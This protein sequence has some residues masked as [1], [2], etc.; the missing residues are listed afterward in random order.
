[1][2]SP[3]RPEKLAE[4]RSAYA[5]FCGSLRE[6]MVQK[7]IS[8]RQL[9]EM[10]NY[11]RSSLADAA[12]GD[13][14]P[15]LELTL[16]FVS[17]CGGSTQEW[18][19]RWTELR[20]QAIHAD[21]SRLSPG[22]I[23]S[24]LRPEQV[25]TPTEF[26]VALRALWR[27]SGLSYGRVERASGGQLRRSTLSDMLTG[28][29]MPTWDTLRIFITTC[30]AH[31]SDKPDLV[32]WRFAAER[33]RAAAEQPAH[34][35]RRTPVS[36]CDPYQLGVHRGYLTGDD[37]ALPTYVHRGAVEE[38]LRQALGE[39]QNR[40]GFVLLIGQSGAG[41]TRLAFEAARTTLRDFGLLHPIS[42]DELGSVPPPRTIVWLDD[43][44]QYLRSGLSRATLQALLRGPRPVIVLGTIWP[45]QY[46]S[47]MTLPRPGTQ[48]A[49]QREREAL[50]LATVIDVDA[51]LSQTELAHARAAARHDPVLAAALNSTDHGIFQT[52]TAGPHLVR[53]WNHAADAYAK[54]LITA[55]VD[56]RRA[57]A[58]EPLT[59]GSLRDAAAAYL[60]ASQ[61]AQAPHDWF[62]KALAYATAPVQGGIAALTP[63]SSTAQTGQ[64][65]GYHVADFLAW[66][67]DRP[68]S[69]PSPAAGRFNQPTVHDARSS[70]KPLPR[71]ALAGL[72]NSNALAWRLNALQAGNR[73]QFTAPAAHAALF[74]SATMVILL[75]AVQGSD[76][77]NQVSAL[78]TR[79]LAAYAGHF[80]S[81]TVRILR[82]AVRGSDAW[83]QVSAAAHTSL[84]N[85]DAIAH[86]LN[87]LREAGASELAT[88]LA[89]RAV[90]HTSLD[91]Q[92]YVALLPET[93]TRGWALFANIT[94]AIRLVI[95]VWIDHT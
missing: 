43:I 83:N 47:Y 37:P 68:D 1:M 74:E 9:A 90:A 7:G 2:D 33:A 31:L 54:A 11:S 24:S 76:A 80:E 29:T 51:G 70:P 75:H 13:R 41:K 84:D 30:A 36:D 52:L 93:D 49:H 92:D 10:T 18:R 82:H 19:R 32:E 78:L 4:S 22:E 57:G 72:D 15:T 23:A 91:N 56:A 87:Q 27:N 42:T 21:A 35:L 17:A 39:T 59:I 5:E 44:D 26:V 50:A 62:G 55:A 38:K 53:R 46:H 94:G 86:L 25:S 64:V 45:S 89:T 14:L 61:R 3:G 85:P 65:D 66:H 12:R 67:Q 28:R 40:N 60:T 58:R 34:A 81:A 77:W 63:M 6:L 71:H 8:Y 88:V 79:D 69:Q 95:I 48:D 73:E 16:A 20:N